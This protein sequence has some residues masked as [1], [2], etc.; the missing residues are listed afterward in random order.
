MLYT[1]HHCS[2]T[3]HSSPTTF[4]TAG[5]HFKNKVRLSRIYYSKILIKIALDIKDFT[6]DSRGYWLS[7]NPNIAI[8]DVERHLHDSRIS[9]QFC[10]LSDNPSVTLEYVKNHPQY[11]WDYCK[12]S[13]NPNIVI[14]DALLKRDGLCCRSLMLNPNLNFREA[15]MLIDIAP[16]SAYFMS[17]N[18]NLKPEHLQMIPRYCLVESVLYAHPNFTIHE[19][20]DIRQAEG[21][22]PVRG[23]G[24]SVSRNPNLTIQDIKKFKHFDYSLV[25]QYANITMRDVQENPDIPWS[26]RYLSKNAHITEPADY[27]GGNPN[28]NP[29]FILEPPQSKRKNLIRIKMALLENRFIWH[30]D[31]V[32]EYVAARIDAGKKK[33]IDIMIQF[34]CRDLARVVAHY[35][36]ITAL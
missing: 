19:V 23:Q 28:N 27:C 35:M 9:W 22:F 5:K 25:S 1:T 21:R 8:E 34:M 4:T 16:G 29:H 31:A 30:N 26:S 6:P 11:D 36:D 17:Y 13:M 32:Y 18:A 12:L 20:R 7:R 2:V 3:A 33:N 24:Q 14:S 15:K 10:Y